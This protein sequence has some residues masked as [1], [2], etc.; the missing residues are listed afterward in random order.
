MDIQQKTQEIEQELLDSIITHLQQNKID[1]PTASK[2]A[3]EFLAVL[4]IRNQQDLLEKLKNLGRDYKEI[5]QVYQKEYANT[6]RQKEEQA[7]H[8]M[9]GAIQ[10]GNIEHAIRVAQSLQNS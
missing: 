6:L 4:P 10:Q 7:L 1:L 8:Q 2:M 5:N 9:Q 3:R